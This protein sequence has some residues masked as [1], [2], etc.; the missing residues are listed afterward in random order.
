MKTIELLLLETVDNL[1]IVG[2]VVKVKPGFARNYLLPHGIGMPPTEEKIAELASRRAEVA[3]ELAKLAAEQRAM[4]QKLEGFELTVERSAN[5]N[6]LLYGGVSQHEIA[7]ALQAEGF[8]IEDRHVRIGDQIKRL[9]S[10]DIPIVVNKDLKTEIKLWVVSDNPEVQAA[11][12]E[13]VKD[14]TE[15]DGKPRIYVPQEASFDAD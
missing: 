2:D 13:K 12:E 5:E 11:A 7:L 3:A 9:D 4:I 10:Y 6:G 15:D 8:A 14:K 1:G